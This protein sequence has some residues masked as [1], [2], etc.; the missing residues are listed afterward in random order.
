M[1]FTHT[2]HQQGRIIHKGIG[3]R[4]QGNQPV[5]GGTT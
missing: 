1:L 2:A 3:A 4:A 5:G